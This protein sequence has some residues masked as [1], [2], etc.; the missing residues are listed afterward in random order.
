MS[1]QDEEETG[2]PAEISEDEKTETVYE[3]SEQSETPP[4]T[5]LDDKELPEQIV[6]VD[7]EEEVDD[8]IS[9]ES[10][11]FPITFDNV[12]EQMEESMHT[13]DI[14]SYDLDRKDEKTEDREEKL[15]VT[16]ISEPKEVIDKD[17]PLVIPDVIRQKLEEK[18][19][20]RKDEKTEDRKEKLR[21]KLISEPKEIDE[22]KSLVTRDVIRKNIG[23]VFLDPPNRKTKTMV[24]TIFG[25]KSLQELGLEDYRLDDI[26]DDAI[27]FPSSEEPG[28]SQ[29]FTPSIPQVRD[30]VTTSSVPEE[31]SE[32]SSASSAFPQMEVLQADNPMMEKFQLILKNHLLKQK[33]RLM[34]QLHELET[35]LRKA[36]EEIKKAGDTIAL[37]MKITS[38]QEETIKHL[39]K[40][41]K[42]TSEERN[43]LNRINEDENKKNKALKDKLKEKEKEVNSLDQ[44]KTMML[45]LISKLETYKECQEDQLK[46]SKIQTEK[47]K[48]DMKKMLEEKQKQDLILWRMTQLILDMKRNCDDT[49][50]NILTIRDTADE[51]A[52]NINTAEIDAQALKLENDIIRQSIN[53]LFEVVTAKNQAYPI[54]KKNM[55]YVKDSYANAVNML[56]SANKQFLE[57]S[58]EE[59]K[60]RVK[61]LS[62][63][64]EINNAKASLMKMT[65]R[66]ESYETYYASLQPVLEYS[67]NRAEAAVKEANNIQKEMEK[68][69]K[70]M[71]AELQVHNELN[72][73][74][75]TRLNASNLAEGTKCRMNSKIKQLAK[76]A[77]QQEITMAEAENKLAKQMLDN[78]IL[79]AETLDIVKQN[80]DVNKEVAELTDQ[81]KEQERRIKDIKCKSQNIKTKIHVQS[82][83]INEIMQK[84]SEKQI[85]LNPLEV[86]VQNLEENLR[87]LHDEHENLENNWINLQ[88]D[89]LKKGESR[90]KS[91]SDVLLLR[92]DYSNAEHFRLK[93]ETKLAELLFTTKKC[94]KDIQYAHKKLEKLEFDACETGKLKE[95]LSKLAF[96]HEKKYEEDLK[97]AEKECID[98]QRSNMDLDDCNEEWTEKVK[99]LQRE[100]LEWEKKIQLATREKNRFQQE[101]QSSGEIGAMRSEIHRMEIRLSQLKKAQDKIMTDLEH[102]ISRRDSIIDAA[103]ARETRQRFGGKSLFF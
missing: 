7:R 92:K 11:E 32:E 69:A 100:L 97:A 14:E 89:V 103:E 42:V 31:I 33:E 5:T 20:D 88:N 10:D 28:I 3:I 37:E 85:Y 99:Q 23:V 36:N 49:E 12:D 30:D 64:N 87:T 61:F 98:I 18:E 29:V 84:D 79:K 47:N 102:C 57:I 74:L 91:V 63:A 13:V 93:G 78:E 83:K 81:V 76:T 56:T 40:N 72:N 96:F 50:R 80:Q 51:I 26:S 58:K 21:V 95:Q 82:R 48:G 45:E 22:D 66:V 9:K 94:Q 75:M 68:I 1:T 39:K 19:L 77:R 73:I 65:T 54:A 62:A 4:A 27:S 38:Q 2:I 43:K 41:I 34:G 67:E 25:T 59:S 24:D 71:N 8:K 15:K 101:M 53:K 55:Q 17:K 6:A 86:K 16:L 90:N 52:N 35:D 46:L 60:N 70:K 44:E